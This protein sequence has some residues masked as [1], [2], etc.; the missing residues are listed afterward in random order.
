ML[1]L[2]CHSGFSY[3]S[4]KITL[5]VKKKKRWGGHSPTL[6]VSGAADDVVEL[7]LEAGVGDVVL[8]GILEA[9]CPQ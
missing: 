2:I 3:S 4:A 9:S 5:H 7:G 1:F 8:V 6:C